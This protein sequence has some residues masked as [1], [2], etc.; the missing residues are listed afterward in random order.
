MVVGLGSNLGDRRATLLAAIAEVAAI[1]QVEV[2]ARSSL[3]QTSPVGGPPQDDFYNAA[4]LLR[5]SVRPEAIL[6]S[7]LAIEARHGRR[8]AGRNLPRTL[9]LD[10]LWIDGVVITLPALEVP[11]PRLH[12]RAFALAPLLE[13]APDAAD[14]R[15]GA[16]YAAILAGVDQG[17]IR[18]LPW[19]GP[20]R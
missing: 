7:L 14:P 9:D 12:E 15:T 8:R 6:D 13:V 19:D 16:A 18:R 5:T 20:P 1:G 11:H 10:L 17:G 4:V 3:W 2:V